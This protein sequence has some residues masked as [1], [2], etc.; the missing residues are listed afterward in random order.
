[1]KTTGESTYVRLIQ[2]WREI[3]NSEEGNANND[4]FIYIS[5]VL[6]LDELHNYL[7]IF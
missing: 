3:A 4:T 7:N 6:D 1:M 2:A 5:T